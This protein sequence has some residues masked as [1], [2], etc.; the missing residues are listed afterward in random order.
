MNLSGLDHRAPSLGNDAP[1]PSLRC[2]ANGRDL[3]VSLRSKKFNIA[4]FWKRRL[5]ASAEPYEPRAS[6]STLFLSTP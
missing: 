2:A 1:M 3:V 4:K 6:A 5:G